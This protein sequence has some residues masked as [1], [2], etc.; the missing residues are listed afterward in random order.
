MNRASCRCLLRYVPTVTLLCICNT[1]RERRDLY[2]ADVVTSVAPICWRLPTTVITIWTVN[3][4]H[5]FSPL[6]IKNCSV[7]IS[8]NKISI[9][10]V[11]AKTK[12][13]FAT[14]KARVKPISLSTAPNVLTS[15][16]TPGR[17]VQYTLCHYILKMDLLEETKLFGKLKQNWS[18]VFCLP[19]KVAY[20]QCMDSKYDF[21]FLY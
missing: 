14:R 18:N 7:C 3:N 12:P 6:R 20:Q 9:H 15:P 11:P 13:R 21:L 5:F 19:N 1:S 16:L 17:G 2:F 8:K 4:S 10:S